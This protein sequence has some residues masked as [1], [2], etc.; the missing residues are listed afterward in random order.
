VGHIL[1]IVEEEEPKGYWETVN[2]PNWH[3]WKE[4]VNKELESLDRARTWEV[5][6]KVVGGK[7]V[8]S[9]WVLKVK[10]LAD[11]SI[12]KFKAR[13]VAQEFT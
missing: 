13:L 5:V 2:G 6:D 9:K 11:T 8:G 4:V 10:R 12:D 3:L 1:D 7:E